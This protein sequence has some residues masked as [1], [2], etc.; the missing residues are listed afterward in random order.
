M[1]KQNASALARHPLVALIVNRGLGQV[2]VLVSTFYLA[3]LVS[4][5][6][7]GELGLF[8]SLCA[9][10]S[11]AAGA[12]FEI[13]ALVCRSEGAR[14]KFLAL[15]YATNFAMLAI[16]A[17]V[18]IVLAAKGLAPSWIVMLPV[19]V[20]ASSLVTYVLPSQ[21]SSPAQLKRLGR[22]NVA[23]SLTTAGLQILAAKIAPIGISLV[24]ARVVAWLCGIF[25][26]KASVIEGIRDTLALKKRDFGRIYRSSRQEIFY[27]TA[28]AL[29][30]VLELQC[31]VYVLSFFSEKHAIGMYWMGFNLLFVP[32]F[33]ISGSVR[34]LFLRHLASARKQ[35]DVART[36]RRYVAI[37]FG[38][39]LALVTPLTAGTV[40]VTRSFLGPE[41]QDVQYFSALLAVTLLVLVA[42]LPISFAASALRLQ[43]INLGFGVIQI[44]L[45][46]FSLAIPLYLGLSVIS[47][48]VWFALGS[49]VGYLL[50]IIL[51]LYA[52]KKA[53]A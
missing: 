43:R 14:R 4:P 32:F 47:S 13:R 15:S 22:M 11:M 49:S 53:D 26:L 24:S 48:M 20:L 12:R 34:P 30:S 51:S 33:V 27:G 7:Y 21:H 3:R 17:P 38:L 18:C 29:L 40:V 41:W 2:A 8:T 36:M 25:V 10:F 5:D 37:S 42:R 6:V 28:S 44:L 9:L 52:I 16:S 50:H 39:G 1:T 46:A 23:V 31:A 45:R 19:G 35:G